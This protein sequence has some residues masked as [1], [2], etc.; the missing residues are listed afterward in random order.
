MSYELSLPHTQRS[1]IMVLTPKIVVE[2]LSLLFHIREVPGSSLGPGDRLSR[3]NFFVVFLN[4]SWR[5]PG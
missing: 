4:L 3:L 1:Y 5:M 2:W